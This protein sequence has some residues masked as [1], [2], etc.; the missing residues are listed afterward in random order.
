MIK[1]KLKEWVA[2]TVACLAVTACGSDDK[3]E[4]SSEQNTTYV[5]FYN[6]SARST[7]TALKVADKTYESVIYGDAMPRF[8]STA[9]VTAIEL[10]GKDATNKDI[11]IYKENIERP[12]KT[13][14][15]SLLCIAW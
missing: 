3:D 9:G 7:A 6:A 11:S 4:G 5:Q 2:I 13:S 10:M 12:L 1:S 14:N 15:G 8:T